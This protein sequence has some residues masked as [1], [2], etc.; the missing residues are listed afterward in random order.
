MDDPTTPEEW[1][2]AI[3]AAAFLVLLDAARQYGL[4]T[5][6][7]EANIARC[8][9]LLERGA[10]FGIFPIEPTDRRRWLGHYLV[11]QR[12]ALGLSQATLGRLSGLSQVRVSAIERGKVT[13]SDAER[14]RL[15]AAIERHK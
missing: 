11:Q 13:C 5:G 9:E 3:D 2:G 12:A 7:P 1:Q 14:E 10:A 8:V 15:W 4:I 6:G